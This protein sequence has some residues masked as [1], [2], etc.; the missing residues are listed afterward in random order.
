MNRIFLTIG[1]LASFVFLF[2]SISAQAQ[3]CYFNF[4]NSQYSE[5]SGNYLVN[6]D[7]FDDTV[8]YNVPIGFTYR[9]AGKEWNSLDVNSNGKVV[10]RN[11]SVNQD[12]LISIIPFGADLIA[13]VIHHSPSI[14]YES[15]GCAGA[16]LLKV[17]FKD[18]SFKGGTTDD[19]INFQLWLYESTGAFEF[20]YGQGNAGNTMACFEGNTGP[21]VGTQVCLANPGTVIGSIL[22]SGFT[23]A[24]DLSTSLSPSYLD[25]IPPNSQ[26]YYF[27]VMSTTGIPDGTPGRTKAYLT[28]SQP[29]ETVDLHYFGAKPGKIALTIHDLSGREFLKSEHDV[30]AGQQTIALPIKGLHSGIYLLHLSGKTP[31]QS[32]QFMIP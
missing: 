11:N 8:F 23:F 30:V 21:M 2:G 32:L 13:D 6:N 28:Q 19:Y 5:I 14:S 24:P 10:L 22:L 4:D 29:N 20:H 17:Q 25:G 31:D 12:T 7:P 3:S 26:M 27:E 9:Y 1:T 16:I 15:G 18:I